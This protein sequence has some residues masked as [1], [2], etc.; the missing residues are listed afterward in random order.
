MGICLYF[1]FI[2]WSA[3]ERSDART[4]GGISPTEPVLHSNNRKERN[5]KMNRSESTVASLSLVKNVHSSDV[6]CGISA[7]LFLRGRLWQ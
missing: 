3:Q 4:K 7:F 5:N 1:A 2:S 6:I